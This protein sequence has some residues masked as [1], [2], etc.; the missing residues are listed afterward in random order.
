MMEENGSPTGDC[1]FIDVWYGLLPAAEAATQFP[2]VCGL[3]QIFFDF[4]F[5]AK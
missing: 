3:P 5:R 2:S 4:L 1:A